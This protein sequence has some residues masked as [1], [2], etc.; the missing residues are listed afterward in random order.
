MHINIKTTHLELDADTALYLD[1]KLS[2]LEKYVNK[3]DESIKVDV[4]LE[5]MHR[6]KSGDVYRAEINVLIDG[7]MIR[8]ESKGEAIR[9]VIDKVQ[10]ES[11][12]NL[13]RHKKKRFSML[14][15]TG[16]KMKEMFRFRRR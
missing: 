12:K 3:D 11:A 8:A 5:H 15:R 9:E 7:K 10:D 16:A 14:K 6:H 1:E 4:E 2:A 13:R